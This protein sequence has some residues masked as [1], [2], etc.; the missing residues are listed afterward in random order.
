M[1]KISP[2]SIKYTI[3]AKFTAQGLVEKPDVIGAIFGQTE[4]L[5]GEDFELRE[6]QKNG[7]IGRIDVSLKVTDSKTEGVIDIPTS[8]DKA[9]TA[10]IAAAIETIDRIGPCDVKVEIEKIEDVRGSKRDYV[11]DRA[12]KLLEQLSSAS[13]DSRE[14]QSAVSSSV[15]TAKIVEYGEEKLP[16]GPDVE[17]STEV[18]VVEGRADVMNLLDYGIKNAIAMNGASLPS[19]IKE[20]SKTKEVTMFID[21]DRGGMLNAKD[22][23]KTANIKY[24]AKA[25][26]GKEVEELV[27]KEILAC[28]R[29]RMTVSEFLESI[30]PREETRGRG[31]GM[32]RES[33]GRGYREYRGRGREYQSEYKENAPVAEET[34]EKKEL[35]EKDIGKIKE[36]FSEI[37][38]SR[39]AFLADKNLEKIAAVKSSDVISAL[40]RNRRK[41]YVLI[42]DGT[43]TPNIIRMAERIGCKN[44]AAKNFAISEDTSVNLI[45]L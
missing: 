25:P 22:A 41:V 43:A 9:E 42:I 33:R 40:L 11:M 37:E 32:R 21:G 39:K 10:I 23:I 31:R 3:R 18:I 16:A 1:G 13:P 6:L 8:L 4:G 2:I 26:D 12:K 15:R 14:L 44:L 17:S 19:T 27:G 20:L 24:V 34:E 29:A 5:L 45:S 36:I 38:G 7:K 28:L 30:E 35:T